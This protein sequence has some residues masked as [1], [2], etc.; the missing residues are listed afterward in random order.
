M[1]DL[2]EH[3]LSTE[4]VYD[5]AL[6]HVHRDVVRTPSGADSVR[7]WVAHPGASAV[8]PLFADGTTV[9][10]RQYRYP[11]R[12]EFLEV[13]AGK[14]DP[15]ETPAVAAARELAEEVGLKAA[16]WTRL[17]VTYPTIGY[18][19]E[20]ITLFLAEDIEAAEGTTDEDEHVVPVRMPFAEAVA[21]A[22]RGEIE[23]AK[24]AIAL[25]LANAVVAAR[26]R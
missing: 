26:D 14:L 22:R 4:S 24:T 1:P 13:P 2:T 25:L 21:R 12:R 6:L 23:D 9:L 8:V 11:A 7:E 19:D 15:G 16:T 10:I 3:T 5:G 17:G 20:A 18:S